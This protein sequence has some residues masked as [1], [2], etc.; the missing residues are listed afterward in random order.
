MIA[1]A[2]DQNPSTARRRRA[3]RY[4]GAPV[5]LANLVRPPEVTS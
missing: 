3:D 2:G 5:A 4:G 1:A